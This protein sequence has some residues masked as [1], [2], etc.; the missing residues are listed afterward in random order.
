MISSYLK[1][2]LAKPA[3]FL[4]FLIFISL[5]ACNSESKKV[6]SY[7]AA[8]GFDEKGSDKKA[9]EIADRMMAEMG[10]YEAWQKARFF[11]WTFFGQYQIWDKKEN[12]LRHE[13]GNVVSIMNLN[14]RNAVVFNNGVRMLDTVRM[15]NN[16]AETATQWASNNYFLF[17]PFKL[18][19]TGVTLKYKGEG[20]TLSGRPADILEITFNNVG[21]TPNNKHQIWVDKETGLTAQW[22][23]YGTREAEEP[24]VIRQWSDYKE[25]DGLK[26]ATNRN[27]LEDTLSISH[28]VVTDFVPKDLFLSAVPV[29]KSKIK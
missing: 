25:Y 29:D 17:M 7:P 2:R 14:R 26:L 16:L 6:E 11:A 18:K 21:I 23:F 27:S 12:L 4:F 13:K 15:Y 24:N 9:I 10:G 1:P 3:R 5:A 20:K 22:A 8:E 19:D 28:L